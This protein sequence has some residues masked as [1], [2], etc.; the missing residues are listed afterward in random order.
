M[1]HLRCLGEVI[2]TFATPE[3][4]VIEYER[5]RH[6]DGGREVSM[7]WDGLQLYPSSNC[8]TKFR[9]V[10]HSNKC[11]NYM[12][13]YDRLYLGSFPTVGQSALAF[14]RHVARVAPIVPE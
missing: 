9:G 14:A 7:V 13:K 4:A 5:A 10:S 2:G 12:V 11:K 8:K 6:E 1:S 3:E